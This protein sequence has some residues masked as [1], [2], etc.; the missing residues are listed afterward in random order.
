[1]RRRLG[2]GSATRTPA[3]AFA[4]ARGI[5]VLTLSFV[6]L[7]E[8]SILA[9][10]LVGL[11][12]DVIAVVFGPVGWTRSGP[13]STGA[14]EARPDRSHNHHRK[15][16]VAASAKPTRSR[17]LY[18]RAL[19][20]CPSCV[21]Y[22]ISGHATFEHIIG[23][24]MSLKRLAAPALHH[25]HA[26]RSYVPL[27]CQ[28]ERIEPRDTIANGQSRRDPD[29]W[30]LRSGASGSDAI[31][32]REPPPPGVAPMVE[33]RK[34]RSLEVRSPTRITVHEFLPLNAEPDTPYGRSLR[35]LI[36]LNDHTDRNSFRA[37]SVVFI[38][39]RAVAH[40][41]L[42]IPPEP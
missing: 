25:D 21:V 10:L 23:I 3:V 12:I 11:L 2:T 14:C 30:T 16:D 20:S 27:K 7:I 5:A 36:Y 13:L 38:V 34:P 39:R 41:L 6:G 22:A 26:L 24:D 17:I 29:I 33:G 35:M 28:I 31:P 32:A 40:R 4:Q 8:R 37:V 15:Y 42:R 19:I 9:L 1:V 18:P